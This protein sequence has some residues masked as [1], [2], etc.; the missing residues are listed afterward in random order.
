[1]RHR[2][3]SRLSCAAALTVATLSFAL[4]ARASNNFTWNV[5]SG[6]WSLGTNWSP[7]HIPNDTNNDDAT[8]NTGTAFVDSNFNIHNFTF[9]GGTLDGAGNLSIS[10][11]FAWSGGILQGSGTISLGSSA[12]MNVTNTSAGTL[13]RNIDNSGTINWSSAANFVTGLGATLTN[14]S[15]G[16]VNFSSDSQIN[17]AGTLS[18]PKMTIANSGLL[19]KSAGSGSTVL[20]EIVNN[21]GTGTIHAESGTL[22]LDSGGTSDSGST[23][24]IDTG[25]T[26]L[27]SNGAYKMS[28]GTI[29][30]KAANST[31]NVTGALSADA[32]LLAGKNLQMNGVELAINGNLDTDQFAWNSGV[33]VGTGT[34][35][36]QSIITMSSPWGIE[37]GRTLDTNGFDFNYTGNAFYGNISAATFNLPGAGTI[38]NRSGSTFTVS[39]VSNAPMTPSVADLGINGDPTKL[40]FNNSG[41]FTNSTDEVRVWA[42]MNNDGNINQGNGTT[43]SLLGGGTSSGSFSVNNSVTTHG[44]LNFLG[45]ATHTLSSTSQITG[46]GDIV[47]DADETDL[48]GTINST[49]TVTAGPTDGNAVLN[50]QSTSNVQTSKFTLAGGTATVDGTLSPTELDVSSGDMTVNSGSSVTASTTNVGGSLHI[51]SGATVHAGAY[52]QSGSLNLEGT[53]VTTGPA[54]IAGGFVF[55]KGSID[56]DVTTTGGTLAPGD[57]NLPEDIETLSITHGLTLDH[58]S[59]VFFELDAGTKQASKIDVTNDVHLNNAI[60]FVELLGDPNDLTPSDVFTIIT[61]GGNIDGLLDDSDGNPVGVIDAFDAD[62]NIVATFQ[63]NYNGDSVTLT[64]VPEPAIAS[65]LVLSIALCI[66]PRTRVRGCEMSA[67]R[68]S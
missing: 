21:S 44:T 7:N 36:L 55:G 1:M 9:S 42:Q 51:T 6:N 63:V 39:V 46:D 10:S 56:A 59:A 3:L 60:L 43:L 34:T 25:A 45:T 68:I 67:N 35:K 49:G 13:F 33:L 20:G 19:E 66:R 37:G 47:F 38:D 53:L 64:P 24:T 57:V 15:S 31:F 17:F 23:F 27:I 58:N 18:A 40:T 41:I 50:L 12:T 26:L 29:I 5:S 11:T 22:D 52:T 65:V 14:E 48:A 54:Q 16:T 4:T 2:N 8:I 62:N 28:S 30:N 32:T 61:S